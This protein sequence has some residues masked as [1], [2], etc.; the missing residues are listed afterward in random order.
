MGWEVLLRPQFVHKVVYYAVKKGFWVYV[1][2]NGRLMRK[3]VIDRLADAGVAT[4]NLA[5]DS[6]EDR[7]ELPRRAEPLNH[8]DGRHVGAVLPD[9]LRDL[10]LGL[11]G[12]A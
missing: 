2:T 11:R 6:I 7:P 4:F 3:D 8:P 9:V 1:P 5:V 12:Q 10:R